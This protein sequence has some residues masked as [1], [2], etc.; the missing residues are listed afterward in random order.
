[1]FTMKKER[2]LTK[3]EDGWMTFI[4]SFAGLTDDMLMESGAVGQWSVRD[5]LAHISTWEEEAIKVFP[6]ILDGKPLP[7]YRQCGGIDAFN[8]RE[9]ERKRYLSLEQVKDELAV[10][11]Q[12]LIQILAE[13]PESVFSLNKRLDKRF[14]YDTYGHY[15]E[16]ADQI[17]KWRSVE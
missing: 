8:A 2:L 4:E 1:M 11:H 6:L 10:T 9:Q 17:I 12:R 5:V 3:I 15:R 7:L 13:T 16:H 14:R